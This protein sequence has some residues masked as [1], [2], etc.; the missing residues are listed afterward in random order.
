M[1]VDIKVLDV[2]GGIIL[3]RNDLKEDREDR[4]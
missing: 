2:A 4:T 3:R 1:L